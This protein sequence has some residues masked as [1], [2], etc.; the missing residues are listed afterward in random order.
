MKHDETLP[1]L[2]LLYKLSLI[3]T[4]L[5]LHKQ[6]PGFLPKIY[7][8]QNKAKFGIFLNLFLGPVSS[9]D[10][11]PV[12][13]NIFA[14]RGEQCLVEKSSTRATSH[15]SAHAMPCSHIHTHSSKNMHIS[16]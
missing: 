7:R 13:E 6:K 15:Q 10:V 11:P 8:I 9:P 3:T 2:H 12:L 1:E 4:L 5:F 16:T 14:R